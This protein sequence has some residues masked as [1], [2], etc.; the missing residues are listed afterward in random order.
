MSGSADK[1]GQRNEGP[2]P[3]YFLTDL[4]GVQLELGRNQRNRRCLH[5]SCHLS[6]AL[7]KFSPGVLRWDDSAPGAC[8]WVALPPSA[9]SVF[10]TVVTSADGVRH[11]ISELCHLLFL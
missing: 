10:R 3:R 4:D 5:L 9:Q 2:P 11:S 7:S 8:P 1:P 6:G